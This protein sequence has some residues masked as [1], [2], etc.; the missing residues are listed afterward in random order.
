[1][2]QTVELEKIDAEIHRLKSAAEKIE[3]MAVDFPALSRNSTRIL[4]G[5][6]MLEL[7]L[8]DLV[9]LDKPEPP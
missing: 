8:S 3:R 4:A 5:I 6:K 7:N 1:M 2:F 9:A